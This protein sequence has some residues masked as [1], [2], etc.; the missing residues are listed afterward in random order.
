MH[1][2]KKNLLIITRTRLVVEPTSTKMK[3]FPYIIVL[4]YVYKDV[5]L[6]DTAAIAPH[7]VLNQL[8]PV[9]HV[10]YSS[11]STTYITCLPPT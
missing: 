9:R 1:T 3:V 2:G 4:V 5:G 6:C 7:N 8:I 11:L 10:F